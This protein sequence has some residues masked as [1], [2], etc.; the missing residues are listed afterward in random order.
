MKKQIIAATNNKGKLAEIKKIL[1]L[2]GF[3]VL[4]LAQAGIDADPEETGTTFEEN[5]RIKAREIYRIA[6][7]PV[8]ADDS[9]LEVDYL[10]GEPGV[11]SARYAEPGKRREKVLEKLKDVP[12]EKRTARF[13]CCICYIDEKGNEKVFRG[14][15]EGKIGFENKGQNGF[16]YD[17]I[18]EVSIDGK[19]CGVTLAMLT[20]EEKNAISHRGEALRRLAE[21]IAVKEGNT[22]DV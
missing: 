17:P 20:E 4:S 3:T 13:V 8:I 7:K 2:H 18:F 21:T 15:C 11:Y 19:P 22:E 5:A 6:K 10:N 12:Y 9:G 1:E 16:G 14:V